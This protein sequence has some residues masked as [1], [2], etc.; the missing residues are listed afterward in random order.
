MKSVACENCVHWTRSNH[1]DLEKGF[2]TCDMQLI[3]VTPADGNSRWVKE[4][5]TRPHHKCLSYEE[6][7]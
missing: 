3:E 7:P 2:G 1:P 5:V 6:V 4:L